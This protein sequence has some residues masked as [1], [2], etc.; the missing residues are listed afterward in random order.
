MP[1][2]NPIN[3]SPEV[4]DIYKKAT[5]ALSKKN[6]AYAVELL[7][8]VTLLKED[9]TEARHLLHITE[10][11]MAEITRPDITLKLVALTRSGL[12]RIKAL[13]CEI[14]GRLPEAV[15]AYE[16]ALRS[17]PCNPSILRKI[18][19]S[20]FKSGMSESAIA[21]FEEV[22]QIKNDDLVA[23][24]KLGALYKEKGDL[25]R[26]RSC[27]ANLLKLSPFDRE[28]ETALKNLDALDVIKEQYKG[29]DASELKER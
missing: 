9:F 17:D 20:L 6:Y 21:L 2:P 12:F 28:S 24:K 27:Y 3:L 25:Q 5:E 29:G 18:A 13:F 22:L 26:A 23:L 1:S 4:A 16:S 10:K 19:I 11:K 15:I 7:W 8:Q 14:Q